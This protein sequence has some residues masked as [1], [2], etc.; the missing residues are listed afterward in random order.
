MINSIKNLVLIFVCILFLSSC[1]V[2]FYSIEKSPKI[3]SYDKPLFVISY[4]YY[5]KYLHK[6]L[7]KDFI[8]VFNEQN[9]DASTIRIEQSNKKIEIENNQFPIKQALKDSIPVDNSDLII[10]IHP[11]GTVMQVPG[12]AITKVY[13]QVFCIDSFNKEIIW[14]A[15]L[16][17]QS[18]VSSNI[19]TEKTANQI[20]CRL[21]ED[22][23]LDKLQLNNEC[24]K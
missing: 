22:K 2:T 4:D 19:D 15:D 7:E 13:Y 9:Y 5:T 23:I 18:Y 6:G 11:L 12:M 1:T 14:R 3:K 10:L 20:L 8:K 17:S 24:N 16:K 21:V